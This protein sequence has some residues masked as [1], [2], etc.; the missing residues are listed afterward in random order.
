MITGIR[1]NIIE[2]NPTYVVIATQGGLDYLVN[3]SLTTY[4]KICDL[5]E[6]RLYTHFIIKEDEQQL[7]GFFDDSERSL[8]RLLITVNGIGANTARLILS[9]LSPVELGNAIATEDVKSLQ[10]I[11]GIGNKTAQRVVIELKDKIGKLALDFSNP[12]KKSTEHNNNVNSAL[13]A[14]ISLGFPK[15][16]AEKVLDSIIKAEGMNLTIE[17]LIKKS[18]KLL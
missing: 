11:K 2:K 8:F 14:L 3:I 17:E 9:S 18:L 16:A 6:V 10:S 15:N 13:S 1:G 5:D 4:D 7:F 12:E